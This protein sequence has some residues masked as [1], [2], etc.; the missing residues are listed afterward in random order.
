[1]IIHR[2]YDVLGGHNL[3]L[4]P[5]EL[6]FTSTGTAETALFIEKGLR[7]NT[8]LEVIYQD[9]PVL[10]HPFHT[11]PQ[12]VIQRVVSDAYKLLKKYF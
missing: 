4:L 7:N 9:Y 11:I 2:A 8:P 12:Q 3:R 1:M 6:Y 5:E 10:D